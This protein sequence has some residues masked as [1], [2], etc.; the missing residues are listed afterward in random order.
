MCALLIICSGRGIGEVAEV[1]IVFH[2][3]THGIRGER[4]CA[5]LVGVVKALG[6][7][8]Q[9]RAQSVREIIRPVLA[10]AQN[11]TGDHPPQTAR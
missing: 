10:I 8:R 4:R 3:A 1:G 6:P 11:E 9:R 5:S 7:R 2:V